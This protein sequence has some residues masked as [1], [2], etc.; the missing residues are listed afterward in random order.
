MCRDVAGGIR[1]ADQAAGPFDGRWA[2][3]ELSQ[4]GNQTLVSVV[5]RKK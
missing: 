5:A 3:R 2:I 1:R 4:Y